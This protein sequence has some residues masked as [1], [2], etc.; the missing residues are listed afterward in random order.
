MIDINNDGFLDIYVCRGGTLE[1]DVNKRTN[2]LFI[3]NGK[4]VFTEQAQAYGIADASRSLQSA[5]L[6]NKIFLCD[7]FGL[8][9]EALEGS[10]S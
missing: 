9:I 10:N 4:N 1:K 6:V 7:C 3:N 5:F 2:H 8:L